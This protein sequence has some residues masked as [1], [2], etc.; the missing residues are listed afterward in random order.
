MDRQKNLLIFGIA[1]LS[2]AAL[3]WFLYA[4]TVVPKQEKRL[5]VLVAARDMPVGTLVKKSDLKRVA[6]PR[7]RCSQGR[8]HHGTGSAQSRAALS[9]QHQR[10]AAAVQ[11]VRHDYV[12][13]VASTIDPG[14]RAVSRADH[15]R[16]RRR[17][18]DPAGLARG[19]ALHPARFH[20]RGHHVHDPAE[21]Q[22]ARHRPHAGGRPDPRSAS[23]PK[24]PAATLVS[25]P[26]DAQKLELAK[27]QGKISLTL[28]NPL[29]TASADA[30]GPIT[31]EVLD[32]MISA[33]LARARR[34]RTTNIQGVPNLDDPK[35]WQELTGEKKLQD[36]K[37]K[38]WLEKKEPE[39]PRAVV[40]VFRG[41][42]HVRKRFDER[43]DFRMIVRLT[44]VA[45]RDTSLAGGADHHARDQA[46]ARD[47][48]AQGRG[49]LLRFDKDLTKVAVAEPKIADAVVISPREVMVNAKGP[50][51]TTLVVW[52]GDD[53]PLAVQHQR[54][55]GQ[56]RVR[57]LHESRSRPA[58]RRHH[59]RG[60]ARRNHR[61]HRH[62]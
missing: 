25:A 9:G 12:E 42:K 47:S 44:A 52:E 10:A 53:E 55:H 51:R 24:S 45:G 5:V 57:R 22:G 41:D 40:D 34:G 29:D 2:A 15:R 49:E 36:D 32:P 56:H 38:E 46:A 1:L 37:P 54:H 61:A 8:R 21:R 30:G 26:Q 43:A 13:G 11:A 39:K 33:R 50:G 59:Q 23:A 35:V 6:L 58:S 48:A 19:C 60:R 62:A 14:Y 3:T 18:P 27:N 20:G 28:R 17:R 7:K 4:N 16:Q 31:T